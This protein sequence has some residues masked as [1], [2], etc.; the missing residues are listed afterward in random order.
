MSAVDVDTGI[1]ASNR[2][3]S[4]VGHGAS[5]DSLRMKAVT[6]KSEDMW[7]SLYV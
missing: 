7:T 6:M 4:R 5:E 1:S 3:D 2:N